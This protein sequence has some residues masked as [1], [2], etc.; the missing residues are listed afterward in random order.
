MRI[1]YLD[2]MRLYRAFLAGGNAV[3]S[4]QNYLNKIN[5]FPVPDADTGTNLASTM[6]SIAESV[7]PSRSIKTTLKSIADAALVGARGNSGLIFAQFLYGISNELRN[8]VK[9]ST[10]AFGEYVKRAVYYAYQSIVSPVE[11][12]MITLIHDWAE[13]V[14]ERRQK[15]G[16]FVELLSDSLQTAR[17]SL[18]ETPKKLSVLAK[19]GVVD[20]GAKGFVDFLEGVVH[21]M[22][23]GNI[24]AISRFKT[25][26]Q[27]A[28]VPIHARRSSIRERYCSEALILGKNLDQESLR[29]EVQQYGNSAIVAGSAEKARIHI[30]TDHPADLFFKLKNYGSIA[31]IKADDMVRQYE[32][33]HARKS[34]IALVTDSSCDL[35]QEVLDDYQIHLIPQHVHFGE[36]LFLDK[37]TITPDQFYTMLKTQK[38]SPKSSQTGLATIENLFSFLESHYEAILAVTISDKLTGTFNLCQRAAEK[39]RDKKITVLNSRHISVSLGLVVMRI[40]EALR[41][42]K[43]Y[44]EV[45]RLAND[46]IS[47]TKVWV[48]INT[49]KYLVRGGRISPAKGLLAKLLNLKPI[50][51]LDSE[52][53]SMNFGKSFSRRRNMKKILKIIQKAAEQER[54][55]KYAIVHAQNPRRAQMYA[56]ELSQRL[57]Q[58]PAYIMDVSPVIGVHTGIGTVGI[59][60]MSE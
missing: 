12:T 27:D 5:V 7:V 4:D 41:E 16:D 37:V 59:A 25:F 18:R 32:A 55:W 20:A 2:G 47:K 29:K 22:T 17:I 44:E 26:L 30:H 14:Y 23:K 50:I 53:K 58:N 24:K 35:P 34:N 57:G 6:R 42:G 38:E 39:I 33:S 19:A 15:T 51:T 13:A 43:P 40:A 54:I 36:S 10:K 28:Q 31:Q 3:I 11:G 45:V 46:W 1:K 56:E 52:G 9:I 49:L 21:F 60:L 8:E 48:D